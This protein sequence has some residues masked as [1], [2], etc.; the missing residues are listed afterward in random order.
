MRIRLLVAFLLFITQVQAQIT[1]HNTDLP[2]AGDMYN[3]SLQTTGNAA[4]DPTQTGP[5]FTWDFSNLQSNSHTV[6]TF[7]SPTGTPYALEFSF[8]SH[9]SDIA[10]RGTDLNLLILQVS[11]VFN[12]FRSTTGAYAFTGYG[13]Q[14]YGF[15][16][17]FYCSPKDTIYKFP[18][19]YQNTDS[20]DSHLTASLPGI[21]YFS[22]QRHRVNVIDGWGT[23]H[24]PNGTYPCLRLK[25]VYTDNDSIHIDTLLHYG[26]NLPA[27]TRIEYKWLAAGS[28][29]PVLEIDANDLLGNPVI[30]AVR[31]RYDSLNTSVPVVGQ[32][33][34]KVYPSPAS[35][36]L[37][38]QWPESWTGG[39]AMLTD[40]QGRTMATLEYGS[41]TA[42]ID[43]RNLPE[44]TYVLQLKNQFK[45][46]TGK[47]LVQH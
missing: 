9:V 18:L 20:S 38:F 26:T 27:Q 11:N 34:L 42:I 43:V 41:S 21:F 23:V 15:P 32:G 37:F 6:D 31:Y 28:G 44:G 7:L 46:L 22:Q 13:G 8:G 24:T 29:D 39:Q 5:N 16:V 25:S 40:L 1:L 30:S 10:Q 3:I 19:Q 12:M 33:A 47:V 35:G 4:L 2:A 17:P 36:F 45:V 14:V